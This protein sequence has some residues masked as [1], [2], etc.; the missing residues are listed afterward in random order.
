[1]GPETPHARNW[2][3]VILARR[4][5]GIGGPPTAA[6]SFPE[7][8]VAAFP[9]ICWAITARTI[10]LNGSSSAGAQVHGPCTAMSRFITG[11]WRVRWRTAWAWGFLRGLRV[12]DMR[13]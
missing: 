13:T 1:M 4:F 12:V 9:E 3:S 11:H 2:A 10:R 5:T 6:V 8:D 7:I